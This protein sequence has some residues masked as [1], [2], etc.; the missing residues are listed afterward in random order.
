MENTNPH[1]KVSLPTDENENENGESH[2]AC[3]SR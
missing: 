3:L 1:D 2:L